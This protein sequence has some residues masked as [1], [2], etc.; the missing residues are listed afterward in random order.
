MAEL[1]TRATKASVTA[2]LG[3]IADPQVRADCKRIAAM[4]KKATGAKAEMWGT[5]IVGSGRWTYHRKGGDALEWMRIGF[6][7]RKGKITLYVLNGFKG[8]A[9][10]L[11]K[12]GDAKWAGGCLYVKRLSD[13]DQATLQKVMNESVKKTKVLEKERR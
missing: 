1:K 12:L 2:F 13:L 11:A 7:P 3:R 6:S 8:Q 5:N 9:A 4:M 10:L